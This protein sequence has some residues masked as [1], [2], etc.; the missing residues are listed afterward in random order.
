M[1][2][3]KTMIQEYDYRQIALNEREKRKNEINRR[4]D[5]FK[6]YLEYFLGLRQPCSVYDTPNHFSEDFS[7][8][9]IKFKLDDIIQCKYHSTCYKFEWI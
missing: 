2:E 9:L 6:M 8:L 7:D 5:R 3:K 4:T 1:N